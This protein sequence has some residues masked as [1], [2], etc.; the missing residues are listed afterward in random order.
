MAWA[1]AGFWICTCTA[2]L[3]PYPATLP[4]S[5]IRLRVGPLRSIWRC[6]TQVW[7]QDGELPWTLQHRVEITQSG[8]FQ[9]PTSNISHD[10]HPHHSHYQTPI[11]WSYHTSKNL[12]KSIKKLDVMLLYVINLSQAANRGMSTTV[13]Q[14]VQPVFGSTQTRPCTRDTHFMVRRPAVPTY[15]AL[16]LHLHPLDKY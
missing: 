13:P 14:L 16:I 4:C 6:P 12:T 11:Q 7:L 15:G 3:Q 10:N 2:H 8:K 9:R 5:P 1:S